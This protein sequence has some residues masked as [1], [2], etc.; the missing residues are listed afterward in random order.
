MSRFECSWTFNNF[1]VDEKNFMGVAN[2][3]LVTKDTG[4]VDITYLEG[5]KVIWGLSCPLVYLRPV[6]KGPR[7][8]KRRRVRYR[9]LQM[10]TS[11]IDA[12][13]MNSQR[14]QSGVWAWRMAKW[15]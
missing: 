2:H 6:V 14:N 10:G 7:S 13:D 12:I 15:K 8:L 11:K 3:S 9:L 4:G 5:E 1:A